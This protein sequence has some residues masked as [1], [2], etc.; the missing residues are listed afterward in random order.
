MMAQPLS[1]HIYKLES[2]IAA[3]SFEEK[4]WLLAQIAQQVQPLLA[5]QLPTEFTTYTEEVLCGNDGV[6]VMVG[7]VE[8]NVDNI[9]DE[10]REERIQELME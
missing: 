7:T 6:L 5:V 1:P 4:L 2:E 8:G 9:L 10:V 3:L